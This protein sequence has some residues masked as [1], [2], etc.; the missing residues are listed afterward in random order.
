MKRCLGMAPAILVRDSHSGKY[1]LEPFDHIGL[2]DFLTLP[3]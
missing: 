1:A 3:D 2:A